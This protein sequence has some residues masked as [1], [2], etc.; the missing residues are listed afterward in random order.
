MIDAKGQQYDPVSQSNVFGL[1]GQM[2]QYQFRRGAV[3]ESGQKVMLGEPH[4]A[5]AELIG[6]HRLLD[7]LI[8]RAPD[9]GFR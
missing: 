6:E 8:K 4:R 3:G 7:A 5:V 9:A 2:C 1:G